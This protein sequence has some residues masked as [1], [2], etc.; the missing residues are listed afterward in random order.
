MLSKK[1][2]YSLEEK[3]L[4]LD[5]L[6][7]D[8]EKSRYI[9]EVEILKLKGLGNE[10]GYNP[11]K[12]FEYDG[13][14]NL[15]IRVEPKDSECKSKVAFLKKEGEVW[16][17][18]EDLPILPYSQ[19]PSATEI[20]NELI[21]SC[22]EIYHSNGMI[23]YKTVYRNENFEKI[24]EVENMKCVRVVEL[25]NGEIGVFL[26]PQGSKY[27][28][29]KICYTTIN[30]LEELNKVNLYEAELI[31]GI[32]PEGTWGGVNDIYLDK[33]KIYALG[34]VAHLCEK[35]NKNYYIM[36][37]EFDPE[38]K[39]A[40]SPKIVVTRKDFPKTDAKREPELYNVVYPGGFYVKEKEV[41]IYLGISDAYAG[42]VTIS[43]PFK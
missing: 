35:G 33:K 40:S 5:K 31:E 30:S 7:E 28:R 26:R 13:K 32:L 16:C 21:I 34:H 36:T 22:V 18:N 15:G 8:Y 27:G 42:K 2:F 25:P 17:K 10:D 14:I 6:L 1:E 43:N 41:E 11:S 20:D 37:F 9:K 3:Q 19:D 12:P 38:T 39:K 24:A 23:N 4:S 29:G